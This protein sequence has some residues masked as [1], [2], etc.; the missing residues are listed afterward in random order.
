[1]VTIANSPKYADVLAE[2]IMKALV[3]NLPDLSAR[4]YEKAANAVAR[5][6]RGDREIAENMKDYW[7]H[8]GCAD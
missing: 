8:T 6:L 1:M 2:R 7:R 3:D 5:V 4:E